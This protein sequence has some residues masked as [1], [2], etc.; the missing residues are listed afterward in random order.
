MTREMKTKE[1]QPNRMQ[2]M[3]IAMSDLLKRNEKRKRKKPKETK[4][5]ITVGTTNN[6]SLSH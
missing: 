3:W 6:F 2:K 5:E 1:F 4:N